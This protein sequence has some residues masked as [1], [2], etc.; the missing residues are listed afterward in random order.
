MNTDSEATARKA[1][2]LIVD[3]ERDNRALLEIILAREGFAVA[4]ADSGEEALQS[5][6]EDPPDLV[7][8]DVLMNGID[9][10]Q[11][12]STIKAD[13]ATKAIPIILLTGLDDRNA[14]TLGLEAGAEDFITK[15][16]DRAELC[17]RVRKVLHSRASGE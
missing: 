14:R 9:G 15:P 5:I 2:I 17:T 8:L 12:A 6:A 4:H 1:R 10:Y 13:P 3:D 11:V 16:I 7:L